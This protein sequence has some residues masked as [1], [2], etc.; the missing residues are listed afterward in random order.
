M[1]KIGG[2]S[3]SFQGS[4]FSVSYTPWVSLNYLGWVDWEFLILLS[5]FEF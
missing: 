1:Q 4:I 5:F 2:V 3:T